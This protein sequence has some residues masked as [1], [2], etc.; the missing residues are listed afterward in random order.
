MTHLKVAGG[1]LGPPTQRWEVVRS[2]EAMY[3]KRF[4]SFLN[5]PKLLLHAVGPVNV[6]SLT[7]RLR[8]RKRNIGNGARG[9]KSV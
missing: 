2:L 7:D 1:A 5:N 8:R 3:T 4:S 9:S 6:L